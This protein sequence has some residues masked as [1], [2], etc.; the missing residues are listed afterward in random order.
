MKVQFNKDGSRHLSYP[1]TTTISQC[2]RNRQIPADP[3][4]FNGT[5]DHTYK[6]CKWG[7][8]ITLGDKPEGQKGKQ[9]GNKVGRVR[10][11]NKE[12]YS[13]SQTHP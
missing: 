11:E 2:S 10:S 13:K 7:Y 9:E 12:D 8:V 5:T 3:L 1:Y 4:H 6:L